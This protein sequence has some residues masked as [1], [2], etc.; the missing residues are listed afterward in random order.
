MKRKKP[1]KRT[2]LKRGA[3]LKA[4]SSLKPK[5]RLSSSAP[6]KKRSK[7]QDELYEKRRPFVAEMLSKHPWCQACPVFAEHDGKVVY[8]RRP[9]RD[10]HE[11]VRRSQGGSIID[12]RN[13]IAVCRP[14]HRRI[15]ENPE[16]A[17]TLGLARKGYERDRE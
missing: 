15:G 13:C 1:L 4:R 5:K 6:L 10:V 9:S 3:P 17:F 12:E 2:E 16:L 14:C 7:K 11:L 8:T